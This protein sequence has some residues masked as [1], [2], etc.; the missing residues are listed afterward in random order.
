[1]NAP[2]F[3]KKAIP[4][5]FHI[6]FRVF[7]GLQEEIMAESCRLRPSSSGVEELYLVSYLLCLSVPFHDD[8][9]SNV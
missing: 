4:Q 3:L 7:C 5:N 6:R 8:H 9:I 2:K 1:M